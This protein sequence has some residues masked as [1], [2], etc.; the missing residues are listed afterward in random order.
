V[1]D[2]ING[3]LALLLAI[4]LVLV[5]VLV[6][7]F[8]ILSPERSKAAELNGQIDDENVSLASTQALLDDPAAH[9]SIGQVAQLRRAL[10]ADVEM[11]EIMRQLSW[12]AGRTGVRVDSITPSAPVPAAG[13]Q[14]VPMTLQVTG[15]YFRVANFMHL[16][17]TRAKVENG[18]VRVKGR[19]YAID[20]IS[21]GKSA[22]GGLVTATLALDAFTSGGAPP[23]STTTGGGPTST[24]TT[25]TTTTTTP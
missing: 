17:R 21:L 4:L 5:V 18:V 14:A 10:P 23:A 1:I 8:T 24:T 11:S 19:L 2:R 6:G 3:R 20:N 22:T 12:A 7:W 9:Q 15:R 16:L 25:T 13:A